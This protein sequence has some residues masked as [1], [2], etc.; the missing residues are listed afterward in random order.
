MTGE[1]WSTDFPTFPTANSLDASLG[2]ERDAFVTKV[3]A[4]GSALLYSTY[5][6]GAGYDHGNAIA[7]DSTGA[8]YVTGYTQSPLDFP[9]FAAIYPSLGGTQDAFVTK[10][11]ASGSALVYSTFLGGEGND[12][13]QGIAVDG[14]GAAYV[15]GYT[16]SPLDFPTFAAIYP[17]LGGTQD[18]FVT[19]VNAT[20]S[21]LVYSTFLGGLGL[22]YGIGIAVDDGTGTAYVTGSTY[23]SDFPTSPNALDA[24]L[25]GGADA[26]VTKLSADG[27][28]LDYSTFLGGSNDD[29]GHGIAVDGT[30]AAYVTG[31]TAWSDP[32]PFRG[33]VR[34]QDCDQRFSDTWR[35]SLR[36]RVPPG[37]QS[38]D[39]RPRGLRQPVLCRLRRRDR[40]PDR[41]ASSDTWRP[42]RVPLEL[43]SG[44]L[45]ERQYLR[46]PVPGQLRRRDRLPDRDGC[47][48]NLVP[49]CRR[50]RLR[51]CRHVG[52]GG[53]PA[54]RPCRPGGRLRRR[55]RG[56]PPRRHRTLRRPRQRLRRPDRRGHG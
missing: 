50:R 21:A 3:S 26:F 11:S 34:R 33:R 8:A 32:P 20:G 9:T 35:P 53:A 36:E 40:L 25:G 55:Q 42:L 27:S 44:D 17:S 51:R 30:G 19:K 43:L 22:D 15:T 29:S 45:L 10:V 31:L 4:S 49:G 24:S 23:S 38:G 47:A 5:L 7:V 37:L 6:G 13:G 16:R 56:R 41:H 48:I 52:R 2:G 46:Q 1:T 18:A 54:L 39:V 12:F 14:T 28:A